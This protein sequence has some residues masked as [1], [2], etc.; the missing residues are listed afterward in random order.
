MFTLGERPVYPDCMR[1]GKLSILHLF[2]FLQMG[3]RLKKPP[4][5][6]N[7]DH[8]LMKVCWTFE[9]DRRPSFSHLKSRFKE[10]LDAIR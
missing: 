4:H 9:A 3:K 7:E 1:N 5:I 8:Q 10:I 6:T 2:E